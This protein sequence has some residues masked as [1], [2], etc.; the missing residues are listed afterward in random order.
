M[1]SIRERIA[2]YLLKGMTAFF[3]ASSVYGGKYVMMDDTP[4]A[5]IK[6]GLLYNP[7]M[8]AVI[9]YIKKVA[10]D[11]DWVLKQGDSVIEKHEILDIWQKPNKITRGKQFRQTWI[12]HYLATGNGYV[13]GVGPEG[14]NNVGKFIEM[15]NL[16]YELQIERGKGLEEPILSYHD[17]R[18]QKD[19][20][21]DKVLHWK[22]TDP[23]GEGFYGV[24]PFKAGRLVLQQSNDSYIANAKSLQNMGAAG[25]L[26]R[27][28][29]VQ[30]GPE[31]AKKLKEDWQKEQAG[32]A[33]FNKLTVVA[34]KYDYIKFGLSPVDMALLESQ[35]K[36]RQAICNILGFPSVL[37]NDKEAS[38]YNNFI[39]QRKMLYTNIVVLLVNEMAELMHDFFVLPY[40]EGLTF[41]PNWSVIPELQANKKELTEWLNV[42]WWVKGIDKQRITGDVEEDK[43][44]DRYYIPMNLIPDEGEIDLEDALK[45]YGE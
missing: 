44:L 10:A 27:E 11:V 20:Q 43:E 23:D 39:E 9:G 30:G 32:S 6:K 7:D 38:T 24:S 33:N 1:G 14:G 34:G 2:N 37:L 42:A 29:L 17:N 25:I 26:T 28:D 41:E 8:A 15:Y 19:F 3:R 13:F 21:A 36:S 12:E 31:Q 4:S 40:G 18:T 35:I 5:Y 22:T 16:H 45:Q